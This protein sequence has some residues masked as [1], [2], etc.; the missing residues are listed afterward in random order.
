MMEI[1]VMAAIFFFLLTMPI[2]ITYL[3]YISEIVFK[4]KREILFSY[5]QQPN[6]IKLFFLYTEGM[7]FCIRKLMLENGCYFWI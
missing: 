4:F 6:L 5:L 3:V 1:F 7:L 2:L